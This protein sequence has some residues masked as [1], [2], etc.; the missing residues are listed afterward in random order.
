MKYTFYILYSKILNKFYIGHTADNISEHLRKHL[1][2][3][4]GFTGKA[5]D[6]VIYYTEIYK[7]KSEAFKRER[8]I[9]SW[10]SAERIERLILQRR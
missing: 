2:D 1:S 7:T 9:K 5:K 8:E 4:D 6:W 10:K 3:H